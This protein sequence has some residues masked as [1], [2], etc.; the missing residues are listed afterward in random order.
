MSKKKPILKCKKCKGMAECWGMQ[1]H[2][3]AWGVSCTKCGNSTG[4][5]YKYPEAAIEEWNRRNG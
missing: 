5:N 1:I 4:L 3:P 2:D